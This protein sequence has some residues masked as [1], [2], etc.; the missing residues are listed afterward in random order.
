MAGGLTGTIKVNTE[1]LQSV[2]SEVDVSIRNLEQTFREIGEIIDRS[3]NYWEGEGNNRHISTYHSYVDNTAAIFR[4]FREN[5]TDLQIIA[6]N[7]VLAEN[8]AKEVSGVL[9]TDIIV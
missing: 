2:A 7:Y 4:R 6:G 8:T 5:V 9:E 3:K 1:Q